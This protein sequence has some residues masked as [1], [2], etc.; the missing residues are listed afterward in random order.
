MRFHFGLGFSKKVKTS[1][2]F[3]L[4]LGFLGFMTYALTGLQQVKAE[5]HSQFG[6]DLSSY[7]TSN[8]Y[9]GFNKTSASGNVSSFDRSYTIPFD[10][11]S[12]RFGE[13][14]NWGSPRAMNAIYA[15]GSYWSYFSRNEIT[16]NTNVCSSYNDSNSLDLYGSF[17]GSNKTK[18]NS[19]L[20][21]RSFTTIN[22]L[23][24]VLSLYIEPQYLNSEDPPVQYACNIQFR[25]ATGNYP[26]GNS[27]F[28]YY[29]FIC[30]GVPITDVLGYKLIVINNLYQTSY[31][32]NPQGLNFSVG[33]INTQVPTFIYK[34]FDYQCSY[35]EP[36]SPDSPLFPDDAT[37]TSSIEYYGECVGE[38]CASSTVPKS[39]LDLDWYNEVDIPESITNLFLLPFRLISVITNDSVGI[40]QPI[41]IDLSSITNAWGGDDY[42]LSI[43]CMR[44]YIHNLLD[45]NILGNIDIYNM[46]DLFMAFGLSI[47]LGQKFYFVIMDMLSGNDLHSYLVLGS[48]GRIRRG[49]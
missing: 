46:C 2:L 32:G 35:V 14:E 36:V 42:S 39:A 24:D 7:I 3:W 6:V 26:N 22:D 17:A 38:N 31:V 8:H 48:N 20:S 15:N 27:N 30:E 45:Q 21:D 9:Y 19:A 34:Y 11:D 13:L 43:P 23:S 37:G 5:S 49:E 29:D 41:E 16:L 40:C 12:N 4:G 18:I 1:I 28:D 25:N 10:V 33:S 47:W 44:T